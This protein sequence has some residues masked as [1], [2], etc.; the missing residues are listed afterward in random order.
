MVEFAPDC[1][2][3]SCKLPSSQEPSAII[4]KL[5]GALTLHCATN[6]SRCWAPHLRS[7]RSHSRPARG[8]PGGSRLAGGVLGAVARPVRRPGGGGAG[9]RTSGGAAVGR[10]GIL[11]AAAP[12]R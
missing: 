1:P 3:E 9:R 8:G 4:D 11:G 10:A 5:L 6:R 2:R 7:V 12:T